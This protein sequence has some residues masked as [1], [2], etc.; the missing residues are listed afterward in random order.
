[1]GRSRASSVDKEEHAP[2]NGT[3]RRKKNPIKL[4]VNVPM[5]RRSRNCEG[6]FSSAKEDNVAK[7]KALSP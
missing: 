3:T 7:K 1:M 6:F 4:M 5:A 2:G